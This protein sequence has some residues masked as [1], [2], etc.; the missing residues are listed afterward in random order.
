[1]EF[2]TH[3]VSSIF[4]LTSTVYM[5]SKTVSFSRIVYLKLEEMSVTIYT[6]CFSS[7]VCLI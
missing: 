3:T 5:D 4:V 2:D 7:S 6:H 1:M